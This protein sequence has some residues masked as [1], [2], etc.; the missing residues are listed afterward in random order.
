MRQN[1][2]GMEEKIWAKWINTACKIK[3]NNISECLSFS[4]QVLG[5]IIPDN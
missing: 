1:M 4:C 3:Q 2:E 5:Y